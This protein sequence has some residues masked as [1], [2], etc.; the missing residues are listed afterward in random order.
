MRD[1]TSAVS[2][3]AR[4]VSDGSG[5]TGAG[6]S[7]VDETEAVNLILWVNQVAFSFAKI[8]L[9]PNN[10]ESSNSCGGNGSEGIAVAAS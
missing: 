7:M 9:E 6:S 8:T 3:C 2:V 1:A 5:R 4:S 10:I